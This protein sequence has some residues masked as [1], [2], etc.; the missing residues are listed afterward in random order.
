MLADCQP[1]WLNNLTECYEA[2]VQRA[3]GTRVVLMLEG[4]GGGMGLGM[5]VVFCFST[6]VYSTVH[7]L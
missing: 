6:S 2:C 4:E 5:S 7:S 1:C 3:R